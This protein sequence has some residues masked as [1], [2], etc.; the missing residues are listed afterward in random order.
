MFE[1][2]HIGFYV[3]AIGSWRMS[4]AKP[5]RWSSYRKKIYKI[6]SWTDAPFNNIP[7]KVQIQKI[8]MI[9]TWYTG[10]YVSAIGSWRMSLPS[11]NVWPQ[12]CQC[13]NWIWWSIRIDTAFVI[14]VC[15]FAEIYAERKH[16]NVLFA[17]FIFSVLSQGSLKML[18]KTI[19]HTGATNSKA[20]WVD[21]MDLRWSYDE[22]KLMTV[23]FTVLLF[24]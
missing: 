23:N 14:V 18:V 12:L 3:S 22:L 15:F 16:R 21:R 20:P 11:L 24:H 9:E 10:F 5:L 19:Y 7:I 4:F 17:N 13:V 1:T 6:S 2:W 8:Q